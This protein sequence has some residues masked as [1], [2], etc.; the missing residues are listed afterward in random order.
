MLGAA[1]FLCRKHDGYQTAANFQTAEKKLEEALSNHKL[2]GEDELRH[3]ST[4]HVASL[5][6]DS[7]GL[8]LY[9]G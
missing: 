1:H 4:F 3:L 9:L 5:L 2:S 7:G 6:C 8:E